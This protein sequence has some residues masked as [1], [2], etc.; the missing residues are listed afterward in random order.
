MKILFYGNCQLGAL[1]KQFR[2]NNRYEIMSCLDFDFVPFWSDEGLFA[3][4]SPDNFPNREQLKAKIVEAVKQCDVF[5]FQHYHDDINRP[6]QITTEYLSNQATHALRICLPSFWY[7]AYMHDEIN[8]VV[9]QLHQRGRRSDQI[10]NFL[11]SKTASF[12][13]NSFQQK[14]K[15][16]IKELQIR[17][18]NEEHRYPHFVPC[19]DWICAN[20]A[21]RLLAYAH[22]HPSFHYYNYVSNALRG[23]GLDGIPE[24][25]SETDVPKAHPA[26]FW[27]DELFYF[28]RLFPEMEE[29]AP[30]RHAFRVTVTEESVKKQLA[31]LVD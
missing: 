8:P 16:S 11:R 23:L 31:L 6:P 30:H 25:S 9:R 21:V 27:C 19:L 26:T 20:Y 10:L 7:D 13:N 24:F 5:I 18:E 14:H 28:H 2:R 3:V 4:W 29:L 22:S 15:S 12:V 1:A 17:Q